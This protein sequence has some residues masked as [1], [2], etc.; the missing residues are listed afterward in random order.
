MA[1]EQD[2]KNKR[3][4]AIITVAVQVALLLLVIFIVAWRA[5]DPP[6]PEYGFELNFG[7]QDAGQVDEQPESTEDRQ[8]QEE[9]EEVSQDTETVAEQ[10]P[11]VEEVTETVPVEES[12]TPV[13]DAKPAVEPESIPE[14]VSTSDSPDV[15]EE[16]PKETTPK[17][18][19]E[20]PKE[21]PE[22]K[23]A[24]TQPVEE[25]TKE[26]KPK[27]EK[28]PQ[29]GSEAVKNSDQDN[30]SPGN[31]DKDTPGDQGDPEGDIDDRSLYGNQGSAEGTSLEM[32][33]W[34]WDSEPEP[35]DTSQDSG[36]IIFAIQ[37]DSEGY[38]TKIDVEESNVSPSVLAVYKR[39][40]QELTFSKK[41]DY[42]PAPYSKGRITFII[43]A[44]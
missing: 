11:D 5:P 32:A 8:A 27:E 23:P 43:K 29:G 34:K 26:E 30:D 1:E 14:E 44:K 13:E 3:N 12:T 6:N 24:E 25:T 33:G 22:T 37:V 4:A 18:V 10:T 20:K 28:Q 19:E 31:G 41:S 42:K 21:E 16:T 2:K 39:A 17:P 40:V 7:I 15:V 38:I 36:K 9:I 35:N